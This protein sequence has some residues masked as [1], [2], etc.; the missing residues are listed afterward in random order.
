MNDES[1]AQS[2]NGQGSGLQPGKHQDTCHSDTP[3]L[4][5]CTTEVTDNNTKKENKT[6]Q[7]EKEDDTTYGHGAFAGPRS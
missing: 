3:A 2:I 1:S 6:G 5:G 4:W 7:S